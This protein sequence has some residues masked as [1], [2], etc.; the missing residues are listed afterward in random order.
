MLSAYKLGSYIVFYRAGTKFL[1]SIYEI[2]YSVSFN[3]LV[4]SPLDNNSL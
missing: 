1:I 3:I 2:L 4:I